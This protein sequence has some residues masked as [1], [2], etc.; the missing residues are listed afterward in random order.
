MSS[1]NES[2]AGCIGIIL[3][4]VAALCWSCGQYIF[5]KE[6]ERI[7]IKEQQLKTKGKGSQYM[8]YTDKGVFV[9]EDCFCAGKFNSS[10]FYNKM[11]AGKT[12]DVTH[13]GW[14]V[15]FFSWYENII[16]YREVPEAP[17]EAPT[18]DN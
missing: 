12:Y 7:T 3:L 14:R 8:V 2:A 9:N 11:E 10:D 18:S 4:A 16:S 15:P 1:R 5:T 6:N 17:T 13:I